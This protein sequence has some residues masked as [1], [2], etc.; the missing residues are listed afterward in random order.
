MVLL[1]DAPLTL[2]EFV[3]REPLPLAT[4]FAELLSYLSRRDDAVLFGAHAVNA[5]CEPERMTADLDLLATDAERLA[6]DLREHL[7]ERFRIAARVRTIEPGVSYRVYQLREPR[8]RLLADLRQVSELP[9][10][11]SFEGV[12]V[13]DPIEL[14]AMKA[15]SMVARKDREKGLSD[16]LDLHRL[17]RAIPEIRTE[18]GAVF[19]RLGACGASEAVLDAWAEVVREPLLGAEDES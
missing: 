2:R 16:R 13:I 3:T 7:A 4:I 19:E 6:E 8:N 1:T 11:R 10:H 18:R 14:A 5:Y 17:L 12:R 9:P 15:M